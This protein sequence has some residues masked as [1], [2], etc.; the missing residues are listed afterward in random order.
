[1]EIVDIVFSYIKNCLRKSS[2]EARQAIRTGPQDTCIVVCED[3]YVVASPLTRR[4]RLSAQ[5]RIC[6][7]SYYCVC[8]HTTICVSSYYYIYVSSICVSSCYYMCPH[9]TVYVSSFFCVCVLILLC[10]CP[11]TTICVLILYVCRAMRTECELIEEL[12]F[13]FKS[14]QRE[15]Q[16]T[17]QLAV[18]LSRYP[19]EEVR[20]LIPTP[21]PIRM[22]IRIRMRHSHTYAVNL[23]RYPREEVRCGTHI[24]KRIRIRIR[25]LHTHT[26]AGIRIRMRTHYA[27]PA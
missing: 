22:R 9:T 13:R 12:N 8:P 11:H 27:V 3:T 18:N 2:D 19:R 24:R 23:W 10:M 6:V 15:D 1:M 5:V 26:Y 20:S 25:M 7:S 17:E 21:T 4:G 14:K 16:F